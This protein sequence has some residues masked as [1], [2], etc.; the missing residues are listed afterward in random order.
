MRAAF[1][2]LILLVAACGRQPPP[3]GRGYDV[4]IVEGA[5]PA[6]KAGYKA[7]PAGD[8]RLVAAAAIQKAGHP[9]PRI[10]AASRLSDRS[11]AAIC[12]NK[13][14]YRVTTIEALGTVAMRCSAVRRMGIKGC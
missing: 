10:V 13:E 2:I 1:P 12:D 14:D 9:C 3:S 6:P 5:A 7:A 11:I 4:D 8:P